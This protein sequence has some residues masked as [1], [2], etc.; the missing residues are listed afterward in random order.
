MRVN[1]SSQEYEQRYEL[2]QFYTS[3]HLVC[4]IIELFD[5]DFTAL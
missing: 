2:G 1:K 3:D 5:I 4:K